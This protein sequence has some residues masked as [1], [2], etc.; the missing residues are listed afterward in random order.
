MLVTAGLHDPRVPYWEPAKCVAKLRAA[1]TSDNV[2]HFEDQDVWPYPRPR[3]L[4]LPFWAG[5]QVRVCA[6]Q[7]GP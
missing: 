6:G 5:V 3:S 4:R 1:K 2:L 7:G